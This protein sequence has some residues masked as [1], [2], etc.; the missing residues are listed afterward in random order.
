MLFYVGI[1]MPSRA[2][3]FERCM[4]SVNRL[5]DR[6]SDFPVREWMLD[7]GAFTEISTHGDYRSEPRE[8]AE[9]VVRWSRVGKM[10]AAVSQ[11]F[12]CEPFIVQRT[13]LSVREHQQRTVDRYDAIKAHVGDAP[14][15]P[16]LQGFDAAD[17]V[18]HVRDYGRRLKHGAWVGVGS[19]CKR[20]SDPAAI[21]HV[22]LAIHHERSDLR[23][24]GFGIKLSAL[25]SGIV[26]ALLYSADSMAWSFSARRQGRDANDM[27]EA[28]AYVERVH[29]QSWQHELFY[30]TRDNAE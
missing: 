17:Y 4:V 19:V 26:R 13:G 24:H 8:Y 16:V 27:R 2:A 18:Q 30:P 15:M 20:N 14:L 21:E 6:R 1:H 28:A 11:D 23:L 7:S 10:V 25:T 22:L 3:E 29:S 5:R 12:M 9:Q